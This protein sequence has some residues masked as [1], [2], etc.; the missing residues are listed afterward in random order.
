MPKKKTKNQIA[1]EREVKR[2]T[3]FVKQAERQG[4]YF[5]EPPV[6][7]VMPKRITK[8]TL[9]K[10]QMTTRSDIQARGYV[11]DYETGETEEFKP[12][13][14][15]KRYLSQ[16]KPLMS[17]REK[18]KARKQATIQKMETGVKL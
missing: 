11:V 16:I 4:I 5:P 12:A 9:E 13:P 8:K 17:E 14:S 2:L 3:R 6:P 18:Q 7:A 1:F 15:K 10:L